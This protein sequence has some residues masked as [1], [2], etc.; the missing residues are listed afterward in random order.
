[1]FATM[2]HIFILLAILSGTFGYAQSHEPAEAEEMRK[3]ADLIGH[4]QGEGWM[5]RG[6]TRSEF[7]Q[8][9]DVQTKLDGT[10]LLIEG[11]A[12]AGDSL[13]FQAMAVIS[14]DNQNNQYRFNSF[15]ADGKYTE[16]SGK[17]NDDGSFDWQFEV[18][19]GGTIKYHII[20][21]ATT[22]QEKG[23]YSPDGGSQWF[24]FLEMNLIKTEK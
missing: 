18:P 22:W 11:H 23:Y 3:L 21:T 4:W 19:N 16:A 17:F 8:T 7:R 1:M 6:N 14:Y 9:E 13:I 20:F 2:K 5:Q 15:L 10:T 24:P 12:Y